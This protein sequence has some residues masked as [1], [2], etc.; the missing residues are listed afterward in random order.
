MQPELKIFVEK[1][2]VMAKGEVGQIA[3]RRG[4]RKGLELVE[5]AG[6]NTTS[7][8]GRPRPRGRSSFRNWELLREARRRISLLRG[9]KGPCWP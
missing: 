7:G 6:W 2:T 3:V 9:K 4:R 8:E 5:L 1:Q